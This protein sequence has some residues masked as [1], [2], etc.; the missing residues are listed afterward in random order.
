MRESSI[1]LET[2]QDFVDSSIHGMFVL[3]NDISDF[4]KNLDLLKS[5]CIKIEQYNNTFVL[6]DDNNKIVKTNNRWHITGYKE[7]LNS[8]NIIELK[9]QE[10][11]NKIEILDPLISNIDTSKEEIEG[12]ISK[13]ENILAPEKANTTALNFNN[14]NISETEVINSINQN[15]KNNREVTNNFNQEL[16][17]RINQEIID[18]A[19]N[20]GN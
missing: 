19:N 20:K 1:R 2:L 13:I 7:I 9:L 6:L 17:N 12:K 15:F 11:N 14:N 4:E 3:N 16:Y 5:L 10:L 8:I 18:L